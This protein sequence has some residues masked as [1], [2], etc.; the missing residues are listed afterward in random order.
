MEEL[1]ELIEL[2]AKLPEMAIYVVVAFWCYKVIVV[3]SIYGCI[4]LAIVKFSDWLQKD[5]VI[6]TK[7]DIGGLFINEHI[8][9]ELIEAIKFCTGS[10]N[11]TSS[12][13]RE[14]IKKM[15]EMK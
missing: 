5:K 14:L 11:P 8:K 6:I 10:G 12:D 9:N 4:K 13:I 7:Y 1:K 3:G 15:R 2:I